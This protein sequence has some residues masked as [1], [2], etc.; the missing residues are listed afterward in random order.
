MK[1]RFKK[2]KPDSYSD[3]I[4]T[5]PYKSSSYDPRTFGSKNYSDTFFKMKKTPLEEV[6]ELRDILRSAYANRPSDGHIEKVLTHALA[7]ITNLEKKIQRLEKDLD[8][9]NKDLIEIQVGDETVV[10]NGDLASQVISSGVKKY[11]TEALEAYC[12][13]QTVQE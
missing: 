3:V 10:I 5:S 8:E 9:A 6:I 13:S 4:K 12:D 1:D 11:I 7:E 2:T